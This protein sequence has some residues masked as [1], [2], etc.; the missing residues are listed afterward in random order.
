MTAVGGGVQLNVLHVPLID[1]RTTSGL[2]ECTPGGSPGS[3]PHAKRSHGGSAGKHLTME[4][5]TWMRNPNA[6][7]E[8]G[9]KTLVHR[10]A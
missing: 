8:D 10:S 3:R 4:A 5:T 1:G 9:R 6:A 2:G 7:L